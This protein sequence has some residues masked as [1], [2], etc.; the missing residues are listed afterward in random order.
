MPRFHVDLTK[1]AD[2]DIDFTVADDARR[3]DWALIRGG[4]RCDAADVVCALLE[5]PRGNGEVDVFAVRDSTILRT[6]PGWEMTGG[7]WQPTGSGFLCDGVEYPDSGEIVPWGAVWEIPVM[8]PGA[9]VALLRDGGALRLRKVRDRLGDPAGC[10]I[11]DG[12]GQVVDATDDRVHADC[13][14][15]GGRG[16][17]LVKWED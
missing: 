15:C 2:G 10:G 14:T 5:G 16:I 4:D 13:L 3:I 17:I 12:A 8:D 6:I 9:L 7:G 11:C 1:R